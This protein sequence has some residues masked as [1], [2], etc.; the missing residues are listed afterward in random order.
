MTD[1]TG[2]EFKELA[3]QAGDTKLAPAHGIAAI[4]LS[5]ALK[6][7]E[8]NT[9]QDGQLYQQYKLEGRNMRDL[10]LDIVFETAIRIELHLL[11]A[12]DRIANVVVEALQ[13]AIEG[14]PEDE[15]KP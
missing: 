10:N 11:A 1:P 2:N 14:E 8:I 4:A 7:H 9:V 13:V 3:E 12:S 5:M 15:P 6:Y